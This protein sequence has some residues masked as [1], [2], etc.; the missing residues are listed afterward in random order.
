MFLYFPLIAST[1]IQKYYKFFMKND[2][3]HAD[4]PTCNNPFERPQHLFQIPFLNSFFGSE[5]LKPT[6]ILAYMA[7]ALCCWKS[8]PVKPDLSS[9]EPNCWSTFFFGCWRIFAAFGL[10]GV[11][12]VLI[13]KLIF[14]EKLSDYGV[15]FGYVKWT[16]MWTSFITPIFIVLGALSASFSDFSAV[17]PLNPACQWSGSLSWFL[18][19]AFSYI[20][21]YYTAYEFFFRGFLL[22]GLTPTCGAVNALLI[23]TAVSTFFHFGHPG[24]ELWGALAGGLLW[25]FIAFR[26]R[27]IISSWIQHAALGVALDWALVFGF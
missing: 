1:T 3:C 5:Q 8:L 23:Q 25:G 24:A 13:V 19:H 27:S 20:F 12:P 4:A 14:R 15:Q 21:L 2:T 18:V 6:I 26:T 22:K 9:L 17:Y 7:I 10:F 11:V 16:I